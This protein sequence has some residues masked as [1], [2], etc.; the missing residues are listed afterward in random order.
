MA[1]PLRSSAAAVVS[2]IPLTLAMT[3]YQ[4]AHSDAGGRL[5]VGKEV[6]TNLADE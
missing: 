5:P 4:R 6:P 2:K 1:R 3:A